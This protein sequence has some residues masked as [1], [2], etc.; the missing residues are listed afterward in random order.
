MV[1]IEKANV[2]REN[3]EEGVESAHT[4]PAIHLL[5]TIKNPEEGVERFMLKKSNTTMGLKKESRRGS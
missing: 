4:L 3:P 5:Y 2:F 1:K